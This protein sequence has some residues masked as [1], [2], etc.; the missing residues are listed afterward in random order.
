MLQV[1]CGIRN[2]RGLLSHVRPGAG[3]GGETHPV[4]LAEDLVD[5]PLHVRLSQGQG[6]PVDAVRIHLLPRF[7]GHDRDL[8]VAQIWFHARDGLFDSST[9]GLVLEVGIGPLLQ[10]WDGPMEVW[11]CLTHILDERSW[12]EVDVLR[13]NRGPRPLSPPPKR[14]LS[15][16]QDCQQSWR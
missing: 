10:R 9:P 3:K 16:G 1:L 13:R 5:R 11:T 12:I 4:V 7:V 6:A 8:A 2:V 14:G 15:P